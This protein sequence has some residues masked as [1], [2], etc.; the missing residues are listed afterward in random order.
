MRIIPLLSA[1]IVS[2][3]LFGCNTLPPVTKVSGKEIPVST[4]SA[5][6]CWQGNCLIPVGVQSCTPTS[7]L[8]LPNN[9]LHLGGPG[10]G[11]Q[12]V[13]VWVLTDSDYKF[14]PNPNV[15]LAAKGSA[16]FFGTPFVYGPILITTVS[17]TSAGWSHEYGLN[18]AKNDGTV[19]QQYDPWVI[20]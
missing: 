20:E 1:I 17:V 7:S 2:A 15:A 8:T 19:C 5:Q 13:I 12:R 16:S 11:S 3:F 4:L 10:N 9:V 18:I 14:N 6:R